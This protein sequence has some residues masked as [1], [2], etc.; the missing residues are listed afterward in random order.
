MSSQPSERN[1]L[2]IAFLGFLSVSVTFFYYRRYLQFRATPVEVTV[3][4]SPHMDVDEENHNSIDL[5]MMC[6][7]AVSFKFGL[8]DSDEIPKPTEAFQSAPI[9]A[10]NIQ[11]FK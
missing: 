7:E 6:A 1:I 11:I 5:E 3:I 4:A 9:I 10:E 2:V 8:D